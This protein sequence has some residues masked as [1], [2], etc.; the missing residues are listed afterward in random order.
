MAPRYTILVDGL[1]GTKRNKKDAKSKTDIDFCL[2]L[3][4][5]RPRT[6]WNHTVITKTVRSYFNKLLVHKGF[7]CLLPRLKYMIFYVFN[8]FLLLSF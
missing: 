6:K 5:W 4:D 8:K 7:R 3:T 1:G 2:K